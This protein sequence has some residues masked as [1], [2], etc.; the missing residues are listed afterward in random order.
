MGHKTRRVGS[1]TYG[2]GMGWVGWEQ[3]RSAVGPEGA[4]I[5][6]KIAGAGT[7]RIRARR[8]PGSGQGAALTGPAK[9]KR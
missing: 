6:Q 3:T 1:R 9:C 8:V 7:R 5:W 2:D 4:E